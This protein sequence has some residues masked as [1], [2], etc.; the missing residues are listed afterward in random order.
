MILKSIHGVTAHLSNGESV[1]FYYLLGP[2]SLFTR[3]T[4]QHCMYFLLFSFPLQRIV[5]A[6]IAAY[7]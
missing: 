3:L 6:L 7:L 5:I 4:D 2:L 1:V